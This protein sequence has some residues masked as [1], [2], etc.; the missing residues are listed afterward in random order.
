MGNV[1]Q[2]NITNPHNSIAE[3]FSLSP[4]LGIIAFLGRTS[5][6]SPAYLDNFLA[7]LHQRFTATNYGQTMGKNALSIYQDVYE[8][9]PNSVNFDESRKTCY[10]MTFIGDPALKLAGAY[11][12]PELLIE[13]NETY[14]DVQLFNHATDTLLNSNNIGTNIDSI[15]VKVHIS[16]MGAALSGSVVVRLQRGIDGGATQ[17]IA[18]QTI[19]LPTVS[20]NVVFTIAVDAL[21]YLGNNQFV[22]TV[23]ANNQQTEDCEDNNQVSVSITISED[24][25]AGLA[26]PT[27]DAT[28]PTTICLD[29]LP[30]ALSATPANGVFSGDGVLGNTF[31]LLLRVLTP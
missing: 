25:C 27:I 2:Y 8:P 17:T 23:D 1:H 21:N 14:T 31:A 6:T 30:L 29:A 12:Q 24:L 26:P 4:N 18:E 28:V 19:S 16:N 10:E 15:D 9:D 13:N 22:V 11:T 5:W 7:N 20:T 3:M